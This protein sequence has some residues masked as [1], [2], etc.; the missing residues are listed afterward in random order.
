MSDSEERIHEPEDQSTED[1]VD[2][3]EVVRSK[4]P[5]IR[6][7][8]E[9]TVIVTVVFSMLLS[10]NI[11]AQRYDPLDPG[12]GF[13]IIG[14]LIRLFF[15]GIGLWIWYTYQSLANEVISLTEEP[16][17]EEERNKDDS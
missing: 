13:S 4:K 5:S 11:V 3:L 14:I 8:I 6:K 12:T 10:G 9:V 1:N 2:E 15:G 16:I 17:L 7:V